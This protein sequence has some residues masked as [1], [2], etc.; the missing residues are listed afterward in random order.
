MYHIQQ[1]PLL[2]ADAHCTIY[3]AV[4]LY[5]TIQLSWSSDVAKYH[6]TW[7]KSN[8]EGGGGRRGVSLSPL[9]LFLSLYLP[10]TERERGGERQT[11]RE[12]GER[13]IQKIINKNA[14]NILYI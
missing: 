8:R 6:D 13:G 7:Q 5:D 11:E 14:I 10:L 9:S 4:L 1:L 12:K 3:V 2:A